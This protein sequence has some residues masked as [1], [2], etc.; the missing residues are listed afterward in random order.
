[1]AKGDPAALAAL[2][3]RHAGWLHA[4]LTRRCADPDVVREVLQDTFVTVWR[5]AGSHRGDE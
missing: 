2:Y 3:D 4:R 1:M 5:S